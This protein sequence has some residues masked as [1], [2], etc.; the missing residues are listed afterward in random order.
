M[1][2]ANEALA[3]MNARVQGE[4]VT[5][6]GAHVMTSGDV[7]FD[8]KNKIHQKWL[9]ENKHLWSKQFHANLEATPN[10]WSVLAHGIPK[11]LIQL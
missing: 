8:T 6:T 10:M 11:T 4:L 9:M 5:V 3:K 1:Q 7:V 2:R